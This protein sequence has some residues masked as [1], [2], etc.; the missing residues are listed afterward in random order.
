MRVAISSWRADRPSMRRCRYLTRSSAGVSNAHESKAARAALTA[1]SASSALP[2][3]T[4]PTTSSVVELRTSMVPV[5][6][7]VTQLPS[8][9]S[10]SLVVV[11]G[12]WYLTGRSGSQV[13]SG[14]LGPLPQGGG[15]EALRPLLQLGA[16]PLPP[17]RLGGGVDGGVGAERGQ[18]LE[19]DGEVAVLLQRR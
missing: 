8:M 7:G 9:Y 12:G 18:V 14:L 1:R 19:E 15:V 11:M 2:S 4:V 5:P 16:G 6:A 13:G 10:E 3:G 17:Q